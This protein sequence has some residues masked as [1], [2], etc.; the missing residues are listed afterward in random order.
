VTETVLPPEISFPQPPAPFDVE[1]DDEA[2]TVTIP[3]ELWLQIAEFYIDVDA[4]E[5]K[6]KAIRDEYSRGE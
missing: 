6:Y 1:Y 4:A 3:Q 2:G 5:K